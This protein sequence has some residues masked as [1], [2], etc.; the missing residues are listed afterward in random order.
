MLSYLKNDKHRGTHKL[1]YFL[2]QRS[3]H[4]DVSLH[5][6]SK[7]SINDVLYDYFIDLEIWE[8]QEE[9]QLKIQFNM[10]TDGAISAGPYQAQCAKDNMVPHLPPNFSLRVN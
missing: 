6:F 2:L 8:I 7:L 1:H 9:Y 5:T 3:I 4:S 10:S